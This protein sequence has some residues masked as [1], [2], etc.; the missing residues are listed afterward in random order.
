LSK[1]PS[2][3]HIDCDEENT[4]FIDRIR[5]QTGWSNLYIGNKLLSMI[6][7]AE[8][9]IEATIAEGS[10]LPSRIGRQPAK[11]KNKI[12]MQIKIER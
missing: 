12:R 5:Q 9:T 10:E 8:I 6:K 4:V 3:V 11:F 7:S 2:R 1:N